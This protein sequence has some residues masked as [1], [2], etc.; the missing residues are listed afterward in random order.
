[1]YHTWPGL[2]WCRTIGPLC[3]CL[4]V[5]MGLT[6]RQTTVGTDWSRNVRGPPYESDRRSSHD[7]SRTMVDTI[8]HTHNRHLFHVD[9]DPVEVTRQCRQR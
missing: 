1:M 7:F 3:V 8:P 4:C 9:H 2:N 6:I 5:S